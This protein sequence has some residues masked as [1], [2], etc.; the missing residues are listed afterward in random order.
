MNSPATGNR[1]KKT[2]TKTDVLIIGGGLAGLTTGIGLLDAGLDIMVVEKAPILGGRAGSTTDRRTGDSISTG[3][4]IFLSEYPNMLK[5]MEILGTDRNI[6][7]Q[8]GKFITMVDGQ[9]EYTIE[10][11][12]FPPPLQFVKSAKANLE[13]FPLKDVLSN[14]RTIL[15]AMALTEEEVLKLDHQNALYFLQSMGVT[16]NYIRNFWEFTS[17][18]I[19]NVPLNL[20]SAGALMRFFGFMVNHRSYAV[21]FADRGLGEMFAPQAQE[22]ITEAGG[23]V[24]PETG[25]K[26]LLIEDDR[27]Q[28]AKLEDGSIIRAN[29]V[30]SALPPSA[31]RNILPVEWI[32]HSSPFNQLVHFHPCP[33]ISTYIW[34]D[35][36]LTDQA[37]WARVHN[38]NDLNCDFYDYSNIY[39]NRRDDNSL[40]TTNCIFSGRAAHM[41]SREVVDA[42]IKELSEYLPEAKKAKV[43]S[44]RVNRI[45]MAIHCPF[46]S[47]ENM[48]AKT[49]TPVQNLYLAGDWIKTSLPSSMESACKSGWMAAEAVLADLGKEKNL[50]IEHDPPEGI[51]YLVNRANLVLKTAKNPAR[52][53][54]GA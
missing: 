54:A 4:H 45:P 51:S 14:L 18:S 31:L 34:F 2:G 13:L 15:S 35:R 26:H 46:P 28:G 40:I 36:K 39:Q 52:L 32:R 10:L 44:W 16:D 24:L 19:M 17:M 37:F 11:A 38:P 47:T 41:K 48:R 23:K 25:V 53:F 1:Q 3:P 5:F 12:P 30:V 7:W 8:K 6:V 9:K 50:S 20:C 43:R 27:V 33:Y 42:T 49:R 29:Y 22:T 21:G